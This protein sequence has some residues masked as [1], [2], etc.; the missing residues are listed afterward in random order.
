MFIINV[1]ISVFFYSHDNF[2]N[3]LVEISRTSERNSAR[4]PLFVPHCCQLLGIPQPKPLDQCEQV[5]NAVQQNGKV[6]WSFHLF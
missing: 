1:K 5:R 4:V 2:K 3:Q 6:L